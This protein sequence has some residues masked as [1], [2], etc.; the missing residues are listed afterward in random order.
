MN[1]SQFLGSDHV[2]ILDNTIQLEEQKLQGH[3]ELVNFP[4]TAEV[5]RAVFENSFYANCIGNGRGKTLEAN[6][7]ICKIF[8][9][10][11]EEMIR[12]TT[13]EIFD[14]TDSNYATYLTQRESNGKAKVE[15]TGIRK[16]GERFPCEVSSVIFT[17]DQGKTRTINTIRDISKKNTD[18]LYEL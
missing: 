18:I 14:T 3:P 11:E 9:Y 16:N 12:L 4:S 15:V 6:E 2:N 7:K 17:D 10:T 5:F 8:G 1:T 13:K